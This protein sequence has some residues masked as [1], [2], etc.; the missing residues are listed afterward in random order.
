LSSKPLAASGWRT[1][2]LAT[3]PGGALAQP[4]NRA[5]ANTH[6]GATPNL[7]ASLRKLL[8]DRVMV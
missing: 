2:S 4:V 1:L 5:A 6:P 8:F 3:G 7:Q